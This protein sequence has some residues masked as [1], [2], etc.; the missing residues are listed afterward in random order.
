[1]KGKDITKRSA[2]QRGR[3]RF[4]GR[5][6]IIVS[7]HLAAIASWSRDQAA[8]APKA[9]TWFLRPVG[10]RRSRTSHRQ[11]QTAAKSITF[12]PCIRRFMKAYALLWQ[13]LSACFSDRRDRVPVSRVT[14]HF[15]IR[16]C[17]SMKTGRLSPVANRPIQCSPRSELVHLSQTRV[18]NFAS[19]EVSA[20]IAIS[21]NQGGSSER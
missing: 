17:V 13:K 2:E 16:D 5:K 20:L 14:A 11:R 3:Q 7:G 6:G 10:S 4:L 8:E 9:Q 12:V 15:N 21:P 18:D 19:G 1:M